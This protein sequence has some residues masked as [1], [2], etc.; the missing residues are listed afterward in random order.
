MLRQAPLTTN[1]EQ[2]TLVIESDALFGY[3]RQILQ[4]QRESY[5]T[6]AQV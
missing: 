6:N 5:L 2:V 3:H 1:K 4:R